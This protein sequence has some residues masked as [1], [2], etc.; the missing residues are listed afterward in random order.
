MRNG[1][2][3]EARILN[4]GTTAL[5]KNGN[6]CYDTRASKSL[7]MATKATQKIFRLNTIIDGHIIAGTVAFSP[8]PH[9]GIFTELAKF[10]A[11]QIL[12]NLVK[13]EI[14]SGRL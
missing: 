12:A 7:R 9:P 1:G 5:L 2:I 10:E 8:A 14:D 11:E 13:E 4:V 3:V 6:F